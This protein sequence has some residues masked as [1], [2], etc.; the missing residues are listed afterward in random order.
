MQTRTTRRHP[1]KR[2]VGV[3]AVA[4]L[5]A[6]HGGDGRTNQPA[7]PIPGA[8]TAHT[9][10]ALTAAVVVAGTLPVELRFGV[11]VAP[12]QGSPASLN[13][14]LSATSPQPALHLQIRGDDGL[15]IQE[16]SEVTVER[17]DPA[18][19]KGLEWTLKGTMPGLHLVSVDVALDLNGGGSRSFEF[20]VLVAPR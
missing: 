8:A 20:P 2:L 5:A 17:L 15:E 9:A 4:G 18:T 3:V 6:C 16:P 7:G 12:V 14:Q 11:P 10:V 19:P 1:L 13:L